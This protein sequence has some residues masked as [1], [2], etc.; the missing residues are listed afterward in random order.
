M[1]NATLAGQERRLE[2][3]SIDRYMSAWDVR[4]QHEIIAASHH[5]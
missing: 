3:R 1:T 4:T 5:P 2:S